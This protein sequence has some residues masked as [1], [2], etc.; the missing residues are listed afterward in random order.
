M[1]DLEK[2]EKPAIT[3][4]RATLAD[5]EAYIDLEK[6][7]DGLK[8]YSNMTDPKEVEE[9]LKKCVVYFIKTGDKVIG[10]VSYEKKDDDHFYID[11]LVIDPEFQ[12]QGFARRAMEKIL[13]E[14]GGVKTIDLVTHP[15]NERAIKLYESLGFTIIKK[16]E[17]YF[18]D[19]EPRVL[20]VRAETKTS[21]PKDF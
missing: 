6:K 7:F 17:N 14:I 20:M 11:G 2:Q 12:G 13:Q 10:S 21:Q 3:L 15:E 1:E 19:G 4:V 5:K 16:I 18:G 9:E 8:T